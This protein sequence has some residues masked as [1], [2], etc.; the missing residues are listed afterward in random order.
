MRRPTPKGSG[1]SWIYLKTGEFPKGV[2]LIFKSEQRCVD[3][4]FE[5]TRATDLQALRQANWPDDVRVAQRG[6]SAAVSLPVPACDMA[7]PLADQSD[8]VAE[9]RKSTRLNSSH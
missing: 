9:D 3:L 8:A 5:N 2:S 7:K 1:S 6:K 4:Q